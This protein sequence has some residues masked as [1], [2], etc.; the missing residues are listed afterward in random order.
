MVITK[1]KNWQK[2]EMEKTRP[3]QRG[4]TSSPIFDRL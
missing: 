1:R 3:N 4:V 2:Q